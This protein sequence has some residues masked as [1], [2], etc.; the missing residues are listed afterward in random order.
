MRVTL[1]RMASN[2]ELFL[3]VAIV[4]TA[5]FI[6]LYFTRAMTPSFD[7]VRYANVAHWIAEGQGIS[8]SLTVIPVQETE[9]GIAS[10]LQA[11][12]IQPP[13]LPLFYALTGVNN[14]AVAHRILHIISYMG[15]A[16]VVFALGKILTRR[17][18]VAGTAALLTILSP[19]L[20]QTVSRY[21]ADLPTLALLLGALY[22]VIRSRE[23]SLRPWSWL[24]A[25]SVLAACA[26][27]FRLTALAFGAVLLA[28]IIMNYR[29]SR[30]EQLIRLAAGSG[31]YGGVTL[32]ILLRN[33]ILVGSISGTAPQE[34]PMAPHYSLLR[35]WSY[36]GSRL[37]Q[38][39]TPS[40]A[41]EDV[42]KKLMLANAGPGIWIV[43]ALVLLL[44]VLAT[45]AVLLLRR[46]GRLTASPS[47]GTEVTSHGWILVATLFT[48]SLVLLLL[49]AGRHA[50]F[51]VVEFRYL[52]SLVPLL[53]LAIASLIMSTG[54]RLINLALGSLLVIMFAVGVPG[55]YQPYTFSREFMRDG[56]N[57]V[58]MMVPA[59]TAVLTNGGKVLLDEDLTRRIYHISD[60]NFRHALGSEMRTEKGLLKYLQERD[61]RFVILV[62]SANLRKA[63]FWG[64]PIIGLFLEQ[65]WQPWIQYSDNYMTVYRIPDHG[66]PPTKH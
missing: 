37:M 4:A 35:G 49:P 51:K 65:M 57:W 40:W 16:W 42:T 8:T 12:T 48:V 54:H 30:R 5:L 52:V 27:T 44:V 22:C 26:V 41:V 64:R 59:E 24:V 61:I 29:L 11:F 2:R 18:D 60:W 15:L 55:R 14:R 10:P 6:S 32:W 62:N 38:S 39:L 13:G 21:L 33:Q 3:T 36:L 58:K 47:K 53:W 7:S 9:S 66:P 31:I 46:S 19:V 28:D 45:S 43:P 34:W 23:E 56:L 20:L 17:L 50:E 25:A 63:N 1:K